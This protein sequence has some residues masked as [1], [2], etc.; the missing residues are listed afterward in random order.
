MSHTVF[1][2]F[3]KKLKGEA[4]TYSGVYIT[5]IHLFHN[6][7]VN[8]IMHHKICNLYFTDVSCSVR[9]FDTAVN[10]SFI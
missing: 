8:V 1:V 7:S 3:A 9:V 6:T 10:E 2:F 5:A 4:K